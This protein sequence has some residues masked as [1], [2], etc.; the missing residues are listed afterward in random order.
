[1]KGMYILKGEEDYEGICGVWCPCG[2]RG[3]VFYLDPDN[4]ELKKKDN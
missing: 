4:L 3:S 1:M 2:F